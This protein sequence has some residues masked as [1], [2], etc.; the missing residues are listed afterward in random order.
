MQFPIN[1]WALQGQDASLSAPNTLILILFKPCNAL[2][3]VIVAH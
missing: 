2:G 1:L 3:A